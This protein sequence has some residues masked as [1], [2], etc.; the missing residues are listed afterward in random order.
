MVESLE[1]CFRGLKTSVA[2]AMLLGEPADRRMLCSEGILHVTYPCYVP[3]EAETSCLD[4][5]EQ[6]WWR[7]GPE[8]YV[9]IHNMIRV[10]NPKIRRRQMLSKAVILSSNARCQDSCFRTT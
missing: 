9:S 6:M 5:Q 1:V 3:K 10:R 7:V 2:W 4:E 8:S